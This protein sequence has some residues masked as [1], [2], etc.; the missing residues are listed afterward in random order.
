MQK[1]IQMNV[2][3]A[4]HPFMGM[5]HCEIC[6]ALFFARSREKWNRLLSR[7][8]QIRARSLQTHSLNPMIQQAIMTRTKEAEQ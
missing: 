1:V 4:D 3:L 8:D 7:W 6:R 5:D 2:A